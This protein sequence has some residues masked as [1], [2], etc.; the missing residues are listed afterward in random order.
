MAVRRANS[1]RAVK[2]P[3]VYRAVFYRVKGIVRD[4][5][6]ARYE[7]IFTVQASVHGRTCSLLKF[8]R[9]HSRVDDVKEKKKP[10]RKNKIKNTGFRALRRAYLYMCVC[11]LRARVYIYI[12][13]RLIRRAVSLFFLFRFVFPPTARITTTTTTT[14]NKNTSTARR[15]RARRP[16]PVVMNEYIRR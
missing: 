3:G 5:R 15:V 9:R 10:R 13:S 16:R 12:Y 2:R 1:V 14:T 4:N 6:S 7:T 8:F 11:I